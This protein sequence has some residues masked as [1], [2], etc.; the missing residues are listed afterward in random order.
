MSRQEDVQSAITS[1]FMRCMP[2]WCHQPNPFPSLPTMQYCS[3]TSSDGICKQEER[4]PG[5]FEIPVYDL[6]V[7]E[8]VFV[9]D[10]DGWGQHCAA[11]QAWARTA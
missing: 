7:S 11:Q 8:Y 1:H 9:W 5:F 2:R 3:W 6:E 4:Y 10:E